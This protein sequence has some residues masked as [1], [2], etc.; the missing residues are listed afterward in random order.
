MEKSNSFR[1]YAY[2]LDISIYGYSYN[3]LIRY[4]R[5]SFKEINEM[6]RSDRRFWSSRIKVF[7]DFEIFIL[8]GCLRSGSTEYINLK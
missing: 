6:K 7:Q 8:F 3:L 5:S 4:K 2:R 1:I